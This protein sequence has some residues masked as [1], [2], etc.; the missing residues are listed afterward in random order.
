MKHRAAPRPLHRRLFATSRILISHSSDFVR[1]TKK[2]PTPKNKSILSTCCTS[3]NL[4]TNSL[5]SF[6]FKTTHHH[7]IQP[8]RYHSVYNNTI[9]VFNLWDF[10]SF[11]ALIALPLSANL[12]PLTFGHPTNVSPTKQDFTPVRRTLATVEHFSYLLTTKRYQNNII[13]FV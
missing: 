8:Y 13:I 5:D 3:Q 6:F 4:Y 7:L 2:I 11:G 9:K 1:M 10:I 12:T